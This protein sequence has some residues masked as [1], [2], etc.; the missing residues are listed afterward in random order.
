MPVRVDLD[1]PDRVGAEPELAE[2]RPGGVRAVKRSWADLIFRR[3]QPETIYVEDLQ[4]AAEKTRET[5]QAVQDGAAAL[6]AAGVTFT[7]TAPGD[8]YTIGVTDSHG[9]TFTAQENP[10]TDTTAADTT[11]ADTTVAQHDATTLITDDRPACPVCRGTGRQLTTADYLAELV[12]WLPTDNEA[13]MDGVVAEFYRRLLALDA[14]TDG[15][16]VAELFP[17]DLVSGG[18]GTDGKHQRDQLL[19]ALVLLLTRFDP[20]HLQ[21]E[22][23]QA[24]E[25]ALQSAGNSHAGWRRTDGTLRTLTDDDWDAVRTVLLQLLR[26]ALGDRLGWKHVRAVKAAYQHAR[27]IMQ[28]SARVFLRDNGGHLYGRTVRGGQ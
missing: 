28:E 25:T 27:T 10:M 18:E 23:M 11:A 6:A 5:L 2:D 19:G 14:T 13:E 24:L 9:N 8:W 21:S 20:D 15:E 17:I 4:A 1:V 7:Q 12:S 16:P 3:H 22:N 26:D